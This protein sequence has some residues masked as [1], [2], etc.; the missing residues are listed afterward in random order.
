M[1]PRRRES[2]QGQEPDDR[3]QQGGGHRQNRDDGDSDDLEHSKD[4]STS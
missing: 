2:T 4:Y 1:T 3:H